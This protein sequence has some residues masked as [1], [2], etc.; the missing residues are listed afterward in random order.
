MAI[1]RRGS[2]Y[3]LRRRV[4]RR[5]QGVEARGTVWIS[6][7]T[8]SETLA[9]SKAEGAWSQMT[10]G[11][12]ARLRGNSGEADMRYAAA[13]ELARIKGFRYLDIH[14][15]ARLPAEELY[16]RIEA[17][18]TSRGRPD[19]A[20]G[21]ALLGTAP[22][23]SVTVSAALGLYWTLAREKTFGKSEEQLRRWQNPRKKAVRRTIRA[24]VRK[25]C[26]IRNFVGVMAGIS[27]RDGLFRMTC[28]PQA[29]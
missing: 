26:P 1:V 12:E 5:Y 9:R 15:V 11:W 3:Y 6:L 18:G 27:F 7:H 20:D 17:V 19:V 16:E 22:K 24:R 28:L 21:E 14:T 29:A 25:N 8:D 23:P 13:Q 4:P 10:E 2:T